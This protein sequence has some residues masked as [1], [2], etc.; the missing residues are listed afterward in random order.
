MLG[1]SSFVYRWAIG[2][3]YYQPENPMTPSHFINAAV[4]HGVGS[5]MFCHNFPFETYSREEVAALSELC[6][7]YGLQVEMGARGSDPAYFNQLLEISDQM[8][9]HVLR[10][11]LDV[12]RTNK[13]EIPKE[14]MRVRNCLESILPLA[15]NYGISLAIENYIDLP[16]PEIVDIIQYFHDPL[17]GVCYDSANSI[18]GF[19]N[20]VETARL[21]APYTITA[22][23][24]D[25]KTILDPR[26]NMIQGTALGDGMVDFLAIMEIFRKNNFQGCIHLELY[27][28]RMDDPLETLVWEEM[29]VERSLMYARQVLGL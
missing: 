16:S 20:S 22:H 1:L 25:V 26:G 17:I 14:L 13:A 27:I 8:G 28:D 11:T 15:R 19:E 4:H 3:S 18:L 5:V 6:R 7:R 29:C 23:F 21:L 2:R 10:L 9:A 24:K 12:N